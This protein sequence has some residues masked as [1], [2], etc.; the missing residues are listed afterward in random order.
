MNS[1]LRT[2]KMPRTHHRHT[3]L[4]QREATPTSISMQAIQ[5]LRNFKRSRYYITEGLPLVGVVTFA[6]FAVSWFSTRH[7]F[8]GNDVSFRKDRITAA[9][10]PYRGRTI[11]R[12]TA[13]KRYKTLDKALVVEERLG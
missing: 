12:E 3:T 10:E 2:N 11:P 9:L 13:L 8:F 1:A 5:A 6:M 4:Q 7:T